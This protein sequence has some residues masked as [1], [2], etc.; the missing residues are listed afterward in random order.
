MWSLS[1]EEQFYLFWPLL[2]LLIVRGRGRPW[3]PLI[4]SVIGLA[5]LWL[6]LVF[7]EGNAFSGIPLLAHWFSDGKSTIF[8]LTPF[9][10]FEFVIGAIVLW[11]PPLPAGRGWMSELVLT[12]G[13][14]LIA[15]PAV[16]YNDL[17]LFPSTNALAPCAGAALVIYAG[18]ARYTGLLLRNRVSVGIGLISYSLYLVHW[19]MIVFYKYVTGGSLRPSAQIVLLAVSI[20]SAVLMYRFVEQPFRRRCGGAEPLTQAGFALGCSL[21]A[22]VIIVPSANAWANY[23]WLWRYPESIA[24]QL[25][26]TG[27][28]YN[29]YVGG[30]LTRLAAPFDGSGKTK[31]LV[32]GDSMAG[33]FV[34]ELVESGVA[35]MVDLRTLPINHMCQPVLT[36]DPALYDK[37]VPSVASMCRDSVAKARASPVLDQA[38]VVIFAAL[39]ADWSLDHIGA[40]AKLLREHGVDKIAIV[41]LKTQPVNG[42]QFLANEG[43]D[44]N[45]ARIRFPVAHMIAEFNKKLAAVAKANDIVF[46]D[47]LSLFC[48]GGCP[49]ALPDGALIYSDNNHLTQSGAR[50]VGEKVREQWAGD[51][52]GV[53]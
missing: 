9:R 8:Y 53:Q 34:N 50:F 1:V 21:L 32:I 25:K 45:F 19:P 11:L 51:L 10:I 46:L 17:T 24:R 30:S 48:G 5:S 4:L 6:N 23:G 14:V 20:L 42:M 29:R 12:L 41:G 27:E 40:T 16:T 44:P 13:L 28:D 52:L 7:A 47:P 39:W 15:V 37:V 43:R 22:L 26:M 33:D 36:V 35:A 18:Q 38:D 31:V 49:I 3:T 2:L